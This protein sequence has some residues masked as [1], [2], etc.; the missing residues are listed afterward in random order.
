MENSKFMKEMVQLNGRNRWYRY[1]Y[2]LTSLIGGSLDAVFAFTIP[3][4][5][6]SFNSGHKNLAIFFLILS[7]TYNLIYRVISIF[8]RNIELKYGMF[9]DEDSNRKTLNIL[10]IVRNKVY[11]TEDKIRKRLESVEIQDSVK[12]Y[13]T[14]NM[15][16]KDQV[17][18]SVI[19]LFVFIV[20]FL[21]TVVTTLQSI[22]NLPSLIVIMTVCITA[23]IVITIRQIKR[24]QLFYNEK[25]K[26]NNILG[27][28]KMDVLTINAINNKHQN[29]IANNYINSSK[30]IKLK[31]MKI[32][33]SETLET[34]YKS[35][36]MA[37]STTLL[38][39]IA[40][41]SYQSLNME[42]FASLI[43]LSSLYNRMLFS[44]SNEISSM[45]DLINAFSENKSYEKIINNI[46]TKYLELRGQQIKTNERIENI[47]I[48]NLN[49]VHED[50]EN[51]IVHCIS[52]KELNFNTGET[53]LIYG[54]SGSGKSTLLKIL[55][56]IYSYDED[57]IYINN[58]F[59]TNSIYNYLMF[60]PDSKLG[61]KS[62]LQEITFEDNKE[63]VDKQKIIEIMKGLNLYES[64]IDKAKHEPI[65]DFLSSVFKD[66]F[67]SGQLQ[68][69]TLARL[70]YNLD[71]DID[72]VILDE[73]EANLDDETADKVVEFINKFCNTN[74]S[75]IVVISSHKPK[76][77]QKY[78][79]NQY[80]FNNIGSCY[81]N[82]E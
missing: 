57:S 78:S 51:S 34:V 45:Q 32:V 31:E 50:S 12:N 3:W 44:L 41:F 74:T 65:L 22:K 66:S 56:G 53:T 70:L 21:G 46:I 72:V 71:E 4:S 38:L 17:A 9:K 19:E 43:A 35:G 63:N 76:I 24:R 33:F 7:L 47:T 30:E 6:A 29:Y 68:R 67:S 39:L 73:P 2:M 28:Q 75:R 37:L 5:V 48:K 10:R 82:I 58:K 52:A 11:V 62:I 18:K 77:V 61:S 25:T 42:I 79:K 26:L 1:L 69:F 80:S 8:T 49:F 64:I 23:I 13:I 27:K 55:A 16:F 81:F 40:I 36:T 14:K 54:E 59:N 15:E 20:M 60:E